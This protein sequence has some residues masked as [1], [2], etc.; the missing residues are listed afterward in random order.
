MFII[1]T[2]IIIWAILS[3]CIDTTTHLHV[4]LLCEREYVFRLQLGFILLLPII[5]S[6]PWIIEETMHSPLYIY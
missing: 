2:P 4:P 1:L 6:F 3:S 5:F